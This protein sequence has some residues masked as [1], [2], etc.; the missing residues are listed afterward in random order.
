[1][2][3]AV[4]GMAMALIKMAVMSIPSHPPMI[5]AGRQTRHLPLACLGSIIF[6]F[7]SAI[8]PEQRGQVMRMMMMMMTMMRMVFIRT[9]IASL[10]DLSGSSFVEAEGAV[11]GPEDDDIDKDEDEDDDDG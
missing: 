7:P 6:L 11:A 9:R 10:S 8:R 5:G 2:I 4:V 1:M 3:I